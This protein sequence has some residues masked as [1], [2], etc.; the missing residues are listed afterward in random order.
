[1]DTQLVTGTTRCRTFTIGIAARDAP[2]ESFKNK[3]VYPLNSN[4]WWLCQMDDQSMA[5]PPNP[6]TS[7]A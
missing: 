6:A 4:N 5:T 7:F 2:P 1:M 3:E